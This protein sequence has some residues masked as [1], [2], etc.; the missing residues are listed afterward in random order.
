MKTI[1]I[2]FMD[3]IGQLTGFHKFRHFLSFS[4]NIIL[5]VKK[6]KAFMILNHVSPSIFL[7]N[8]VY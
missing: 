4:V 6:G 2:V 8:R 3:Q 1:L 7:S 5:K